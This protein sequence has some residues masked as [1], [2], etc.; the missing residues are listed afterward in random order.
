MKKIYD[1]LELSENKEEYMN[2]IYEVLLSS[3]EEVILTTLGKILPLKNTNEILYLFYIGKMCQY[4]VDSINKILQAKE[5]EQIIEKIN[6]KIFDIM[7]KNLNFL[8]DDIQGSNMKLNRFVVKNKILNE[9]F[10]VIPIFL[11]NKT[12]LENLS[13]YEFNFSENYWKEKNNLVKE[14]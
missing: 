1:Y 14:A 11:E 3:I 13:N 6:N 12:F 7:D 9:A 8:I 2:K 4:L 5:K 10:N